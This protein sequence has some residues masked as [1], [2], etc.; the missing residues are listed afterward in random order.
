[1]K[2]YTFE[3]IEIK[4]FE[5]KYELNIPHKTAAARPDEQYCLEKLIPQSISCFSFPL[6]LSDTL[7]KSSAFTEDVFGVMT[8]AELS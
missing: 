7:N 6:Q 5:K 8:E 2:R 3:D 4:T 1:M